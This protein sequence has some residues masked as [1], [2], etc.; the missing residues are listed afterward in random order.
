[1][2]NKGTLF[3]FLDKYF[4]SLSALQF[5]PAPSLHIYANVTGSDDHTV[6]VWRADTGWCVGLL[7]TSSST[8][9]SS[10]G[11][12][13]WIPESITSMFI[14]PGAPKRGVQRVFLLT[15]HPHIVISSSRFEVTVWNVQIGA[16]LYAPIEY[17]CKSFKFGV[18]AQFCLDN[19]SLLV[20]GD[21]LV[22]ST[23]EP[24][25]IEVRNLQ[26]GTMLH[27]MRNRSLINCMAPVPG[28][29]DYIV[30][31]DTTGNVQVWDILAGLN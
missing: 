31:G 12:N 23:W 15:T 7:D 19:A 21:C 4:S 5:S 20:I 28:K 17:R 6:R 27:S 30:T 1:V 11:Y 22:T 9:S 3:F 18:Q 16:R 2:C 8:S 24:C 10:G 25:A 26:T 29:S 13:N 14:T